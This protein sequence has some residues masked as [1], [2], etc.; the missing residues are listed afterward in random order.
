M[1][2]NVPSNECRTV[3]EPGLTFRVLQ[4]PQVPIKAAQAPGAILPAP[5]SRPYLANT[6]METD[7]RSDCMGCHSAAKVTPEIPGTAT[8]GTDFMYWLQLEVPG[9]PKPE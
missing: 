5:T 7:V 3:Q 8:P 4:Q 2:Y 9:G 6:S 1:W